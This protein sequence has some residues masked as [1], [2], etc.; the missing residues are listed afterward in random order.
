[1]QEM[2]VRTKTNDDS[3]DTDASG[4]Q[5]KERVLSLSM[6]ET[7]PGTLEFEW[8]SDVEI[9]ERVAIKT[10]PTVASTSNMLRH[11]WCPCHSSYQITQPPSLKFQ[12]NQ[13]SHIYPNSSPKSLKIGWI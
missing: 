7:R 3:V 11:P 5:M 2:V 10:G 1:M 6:L 13:K 8:S 9:F 4:E 12:D